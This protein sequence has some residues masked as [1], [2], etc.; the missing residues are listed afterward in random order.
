M[1]RGGGESK[2]WEG[3]VLFFVLNKSNN[4]AEAFP[5]E[6]FLQLA[7]VNCNRRKKN[8]QL[9]SAFTF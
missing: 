4:A 5:V 1:A 2:R 8:F 6:F 9:Q 3:C 7:E